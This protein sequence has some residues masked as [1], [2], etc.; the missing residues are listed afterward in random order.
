[1]NLNPKLISEFALGDELTTKTNISSF[2]DP[3]GIY[4]S[5]ADVSFGSPINMD[6]IVFAAMREPVAKRVVVADC[7]VRVKQRS[8][9]F[10]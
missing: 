3:Q 10:S 6:Q 7:L 2:D 4:G 8:L 9:A 1:M 5:T